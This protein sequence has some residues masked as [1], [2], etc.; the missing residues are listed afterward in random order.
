MQPVEYALRLTQIGEQ[1]APAARGGAV[2]TSV[3]LMKEEKEEREGEETWGVMK[4]KINT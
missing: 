3:R 4:T 1:T 2:E